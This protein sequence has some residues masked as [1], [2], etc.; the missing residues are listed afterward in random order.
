MNRIVVAMSG[1]VD[2]SLAAALLVEQGYD[3]I[4]VAMRLWESGDSESGC[5]SLDD[6]L[7]ARRVAEQ[8]GIP[9][10][11]M[12]FRA[13]FGR[14]VVDDFVAEYRRGRTPNPCARCN[15]FVKFSALWDRARELGASAIATGHYARLR[16]GADGPELLRGV[17]VDKDQSY[18]LFAVDPAVLAQ[19]RFPVGEMTKRTVRAEAARRGLAVAG[20]PDSQEVCFAPRSTYAAFVEQRSSHE[21]LRP[22]AVVDEHGVELARHDGVHR[23]TIGQRRRLGVSGTAARYVTDIDAARGIVRTGG[24]ADVAAEGLVASGANWLAAIPGPGTGV[25]VKIRSRFVPQAARITRA[26]RDGF[27]LAADGDMRA[28]TPGQ[29][30]VLYDGERVIGGGW[31]AHAIGAARSAVALP[32]DTQAMSASHRLPSDPE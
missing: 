4:G 30:A 17:D 24:A 31:I 9:F 20:K 1:G 6:F 28:V 11:V 26:D 12:D 15:Q 13:A 22:G 5:C 27:E 25:S 10:Y 18:F 14:A 16:S 23:F 32:P 7:D 21:P 2:S 3:V 19:T 8:L 29:A